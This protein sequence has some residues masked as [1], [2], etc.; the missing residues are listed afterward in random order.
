[1]VRSSLV[2]AAII[3]TDQSA[4]PCSSD[5]DHTEQSARRCADRNRIT[6][7][8]DVS[9]FFSSF[10]SLSIQG[11]SQSSRMFLLSSLPS[12]LSLSG[13]IT[14][15]PDVSSFFSS[16]SSLSIRDHHRAAGCFCFLLFLLL[17]LYQGS[18]RSSRMF[19]LSSLP[20]PLSLSLYQGSSQS[21]RMFLLSSL[22]SPLSLSG[23]ITEQPDVSSFFSSFSSLSIRDHHRAAGC[24][25]FLLFLLL[26]LYQGSSQSSR[27]FLLS[28][29]PSPLSLSLSGIITEQPDVSSFFSSFSSL[30]LYQGSSQ[31]SRMFLLSSLP[32]PLSIRDHH[33]AA[34]CFFFLLFLLLS[35]RDHHRAAGCFFFFFPLSLSFRNH[36]RA[37]GCFF[38]FLLS[39]LD[40]NHHSVDGGLS[41]FFFLSL[42]LLI[43]EPWVVVVFSSPSSSF[44]FVHRSPPPPPP[45]FPPTPLPT[46]VNK[47]RTV[48]KKCQ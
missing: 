16:F 41:Y 12:P 46:P 29:L 27:M 22:P 19:L 5:N 10:S 30:S 43:A 14:E 7:Q 1:M 21:S 36:H 34:G 9:A 20:S 23:I 38:F 17:S 33:R 13:I 48:H 3:T 8:P 26:S 28:S 37:A 15:Q 25:C 44:R 40:R 45:L 24:F 11:S 2:L 47:L 4:S 6:E 35:I 39:L 32:S 31:S 42:S 18:S